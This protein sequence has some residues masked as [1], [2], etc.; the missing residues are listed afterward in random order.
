MV[1]HLG[2]KQIQHAVA[3]DFSRAE[4]EDFINVYVDYFMK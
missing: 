4:L 1:A 2:G 3:Q